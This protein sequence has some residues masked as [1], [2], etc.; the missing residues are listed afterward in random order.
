MNDVQFQIPRLDG[1]GVNTVIFNEISVIDVT[2]PA[3]EDNQ[4]IVVKVT[5]L[6][7]SDNALLWRSCSLNCQGSLYADD[8][9]PNG[10]FALRSV[11][12]H[13]DGRQEATFEEV[14]DDD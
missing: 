7:C 5:F 1:L 14:L 6:G 8:L 10:P 3:P 12:F 2:K 13:A 9:T 4:P 11:K